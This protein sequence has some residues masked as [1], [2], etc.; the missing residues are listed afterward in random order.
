MGSLLDSYVKG[1][2]QKANARLQNLQMCTVL[3]IMTT[4][5]CIIGILR[6]VDRVLVSIV[7]RFDRLC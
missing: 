1:H 4:T 7:V 2:L 6:N 5:L 3:T